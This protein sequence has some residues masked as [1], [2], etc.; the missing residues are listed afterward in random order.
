MSSLDILQERLELALRDG[1]PHEDREVA[2][3]IRGEGHRLVFLLN[4]LVRATRLYALDNDALAGPAAELGEVIG[5][6]VDRLGVV[7]LMLVED[8]AYVNDVRLRVRPLE[9]M[10]V[11][12]L[13]AEFARHQIGGLSIHHR[14]PPDRVKLLALELSGPAPAEQPAA[15]LRARLAAVGDLELSGRWRFRLGGDEEQLGPKTHAEIL[16]RA[17]AA[18]RDALGRVA[19]G[20]MPN[21][22]PIRRVVIDLVEGL[23]R[24]P[25]R[26]AVAPFAGRFGASER[27]LLSVCQL[28]LLLGRELGLSEAQLSDLGVAALLH[29]VGYLTSQDPIGH[30][31]AGARLLMRQRGFGEAK[32]RRLRAVL[33]HHDGERPGSQRGRATSLFARILHVADQYDLLVAPRHGTLDRSVAPA[34][35]LARLWAGRGGRFDADLVAL[36]A[37]ALGLYPA[38]TLLELVDGSWAVVERSGTGPERWSRPVVRVVRACDGSVGPAAETIDLGERADEAGI[39]QVIEPSAAGCGITSAVQAVLEAAAD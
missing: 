9:Q 3:Q 24:R 29:D 37:R 7:H 10:V 2:A 26:A 27:H 8:Q 32:L 21:P 13:S 35:A 36:F 6:L 14:L 15:A 25:E 34:T 19:A 28:S 11:D 17:E 23:A 4:G 18:V 33:E 1:G 16:A 38:G 39:K 5:V 12:Q 31:L 20:W 22:L 30:A